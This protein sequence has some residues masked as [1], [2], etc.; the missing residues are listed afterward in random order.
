MN[1][2]NFKTKLFLDMSKAE[3]ISRSIVFIDNVFSNIK[4]EPNKPI[5]L[6][7]KNPFDVVANPLFL[8]SRVN[9]NVVEKPNSDQMHRELSWNEDAFNMIYDLLPP[10]LEIKHISTVNDNRIIEISKDIISFAG[11]ENSIG[12][13]GINYEMF[14]EDNRINLKDYLLKENIAKGF[15]SLS[16]TPVFQIDENTVL[17]LTVA[18]SV[19]NSGKNGIYFQVNFDNKVATN[20]SVSNILEK[21]F[22]EIANEKIKL[23]FG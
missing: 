7:I 15:T 2:F 1:F 10:R 8:K 16:A 11:L 14:L 6:Q 23:I 21:D 9:T 20:N 4:F 18:S 3:M 13:I 22:L 12:K 5:Q 17:N 19:N